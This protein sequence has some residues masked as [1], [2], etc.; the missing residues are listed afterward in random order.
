MSKMQRT[1]FAALMAKLRA[2]YQNPV[3]DKSQWLASLSTYWELLHGYGDTDI[4]AAFALAWRKHVD[5]M[6]SAGQ[7]ARL[8]EDRCEASADDAW[9]EVLRLATR[10]SSDHSDPIAREAIKAMGGGARLGAMRLDELQGWGRKEFREAYARLRKRKDIDDAVA[11]A[12]LAQGHPGRIKE[13]QG[14]G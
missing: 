13:S 11:A 4:R 12:E 5:W 9:P 10:S 6:P 1:E 3:S 2:C 7:L 14:Q 8:I